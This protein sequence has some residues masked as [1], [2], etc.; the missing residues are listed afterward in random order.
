VYGTGFAPGGG[1]DWRMMDVMAG[2][3]QEHMMRMSD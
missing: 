3:A 2:A 1:G